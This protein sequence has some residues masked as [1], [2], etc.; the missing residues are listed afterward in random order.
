M[1]YLATYML[2]LP[3]EDLTTN[4]PQEFEAFIFLDFKTILK[5]L[6]VALSETFIN[7][8]SVILGIA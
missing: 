3:H 4:G 5:K 2:I 6:L 7:K 1:D 8:N